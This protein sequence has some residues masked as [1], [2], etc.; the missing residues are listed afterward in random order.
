MVATN[1]SDR[2]A[3]GV[4][5]WVVITVACG[6]GCNAISGAAGVSVVAA[7]GLTPLSAGRGLAGGVSRSGD[8]VKAAQVNAATG[9]ALPTG[10][11]SLGGIAV[12]AGSVVG[13][14]VIV[15]SRSIGGMSARTSS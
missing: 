4:G 5:I 1:V 2:V 9:S 14:G 10:A 13:A 3:A 12:G 8:E 15:V 11:F 7:G 6:P